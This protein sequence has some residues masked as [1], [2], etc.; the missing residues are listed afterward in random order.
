MDGRNY[1]VQQKLGKRKKKKK[2]E[3]KVCMTYNLKYISENKK[4]ISN[5][6]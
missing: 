1:L 2:L 5:I 3:N 6:S 4:E